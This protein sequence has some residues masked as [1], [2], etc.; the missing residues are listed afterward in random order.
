M[1]TFSEI[2]DAFLFVNSAEEGMNRAILCKDTGLIFFRSEWGDI[3]EMDDEELDCDEFVEIPHKNE[4]DLGQNLVFEF[5]EEYLAGECDLVS[6]IFQ[7]RGAHGR[8]KDLLAQKSL[9]KSWYGFQNRR[10]EEA[11]RQWCLENEIEMAPEQ[12]AP[13][14]L[15]SEDQELM[16]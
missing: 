12:A 2:H 1:F 7:R 11:L 8:F 13:P 16:K 14:G 4:L 6:E 3:N 15:R 5:A 9:L 10:E